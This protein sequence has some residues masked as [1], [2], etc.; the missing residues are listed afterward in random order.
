MFAQGGLGFFIAMGGEVVEDHGSAWLDLGDKHI[1][2]VGDK[3]R[4]IHRPFDD[5]GRYQIGWPQ[6]GDQGLG[7]P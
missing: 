5:P 4:S 7:S 3:G 2:D 1:S 6:S